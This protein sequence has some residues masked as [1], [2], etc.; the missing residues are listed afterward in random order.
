MQMLKQI[1]NR[2]VPPRYEHAPAPVDA[3][4]AMPSVISS[5]DDEARPS[6]RLLSLAVEAAEAARLVC[7]D[8]LAMRPGVPGEFVVWPGEHY[9]LLSGLMRALN[10]QVVVQIGVWMGLEALAMRKYLPP[11]GRIVMFDPT[12]WDTVA[13]TVLREADFADGRLTQEIEDLTTEAGLARHRGLL[14]SADFILV[15]GPE[16]GQTERKL[17][18]GLGR[19]RFEKRPVAMFDGTRLWPMLRFWRQIA[20]PKLDLT[21]FGHWSGTGWVELPT[22]ESARR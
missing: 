4:M 9:R 16:D 21:S 19:L 8:D 1:A 7:L 20:H 15:D 10:P 11:G 6:H 14:E 22:G 2:I 13:G 5:A 3:A 18:E 12:R 17:L